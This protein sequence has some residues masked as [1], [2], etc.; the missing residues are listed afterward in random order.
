MSSLI[1]KSEDFKHKMTRRP[2]AAPFI[3]AFLHQPS[4]PGGSSRENTA[5]RW[6]QRHK[7]QKRGELINDNMKGT[8]RRAD[9]D[10]SLAY[11]VQIREQ[12]LALFV[13]DQFPSWC[14]HW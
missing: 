1:A 4:E 10:S 9:E 13:S 3:K 14:F 11:L 7:E 5:I 12:D 2:L 8:Q 6:R